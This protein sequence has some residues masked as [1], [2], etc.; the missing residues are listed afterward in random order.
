MRNRLALPPAKTEMR[1]IAPNSISGLIQANNHI[2][3]GNDLF[4]KLRAGS[5]WVADKHIDV[6]R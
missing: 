4:G 5:S 1:K 2:T 3:N 6:F